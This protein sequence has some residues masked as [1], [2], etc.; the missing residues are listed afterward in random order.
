MAPGTVMNDDLD[1]YGVDDF[2]VDPFAVSSD[3]NADKAD[4][5]TNKRKDV[6]GLGIDEAVA[7]SKKAR[8]P[9]V[10]LDDKKLLSDKGIPKLRRKAGD[11]KFKGKGHEVG[12]R[13]VFILSCILTEVTS[14]QTQPDSSPSINFG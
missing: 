11:L 6:A 1:N 14:S 10:K 3:E 9:R 5:Q 8:V 7:V 13:N 4:S 12:A 2:G